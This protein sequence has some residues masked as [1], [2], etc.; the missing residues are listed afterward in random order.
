M[1]LSEVLQ[2]VQILSILI[3]GGILIH[4]HGRSSESTALALAAHRTEI[5][6]LKTEVKKLG[7]I[8]TNQRVFQQSLLRLEERYDEL[9]RGIGW[10]VQPPAKFTRPQQADPDR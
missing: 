9:R 4:R 8:L 2:I 6:E 3:G 10:I 1:T 5:S 7:E